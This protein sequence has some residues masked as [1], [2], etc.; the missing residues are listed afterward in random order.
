MVQSG[1]LVAPRPSSPSAKRVRLDSPAPKSS[2][3]ARIDDLDM[4]DL[5]ALDMSLTDAADALLQR[6][7]YFL[8]TEGGLMRVYV[9]LDD[10]AVQ[11][12]L[13]R[14]LVE[15]PGQLVSAQ[16]Q[17]INAFESTSA[18]RRSMSAPREAT[19]QVPLSLPKFKPV[20]MTAAELLICWFEREVE[21]H[22]PL[23]L[24][25]P[26]A[27]TVWSSSSVSVH[28][29]GTFS[30]L[31]KAYVYVRSCMNQSPSDATCCLADLKKRSNEH[32]SAVK[33]ASWYERAL[34]CYDSV[35]GS[36]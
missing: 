13:Q 29:S 25:T 36:V 10:D 5:A 20:C 18:A 21:E 9:A 31:C 34:E 4:D 3:S 32:L 24:W 27:R 6:C 23:R 14:G 8:A 7:R 30:Q 26:T 22:P 35:Y 2:F 16:D 12:M 1:R 15:I 28:N 19:V 11:R 33:D 17:V